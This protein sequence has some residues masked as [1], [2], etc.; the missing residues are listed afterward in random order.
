MS[1]SDCLFCEQAGGEVLWSDARCRIVWPQET[2]YPGLCRVVWK[3][4]TKEMSDLCG[5]DRVHLMHV[6]FAVE[7][8]LRDLLAPDKVNL[9]SFGNVVPHIHWHIIPRNRDDA[10]FPGSIW[11]AKQREFVAPLPEDF[12]AQLRNRLATVLRS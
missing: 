11:S 9:A 3:V 2:D 6:V 8:A 4:H 12:S 5:E 10:H 7:A 1:S